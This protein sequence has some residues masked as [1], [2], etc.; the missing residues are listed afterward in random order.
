[1]AYPDSWN[2]YDSLAEA[3]LA[4]GNI[5]LVIFYYEKALKMNPGNGQAVKQ[6]KNPKK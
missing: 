1:M 5:E 4:D 3:Y 6:L 2:T